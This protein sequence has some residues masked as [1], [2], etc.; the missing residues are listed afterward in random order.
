MASHSKIL[1]VSVLSTFTSSIVSGTDA[2]YSVYRHESQSIYHSQSVAVEDQSSSGYSVASLDTDSSWSMDNGEMTDSMDEILQNSDS[3]DFEVFVTT[4]DSAE[5]TELLWTDFSSTNEYEYDSIEMPSEEPGH[6]Y[7]FKDNQGEEHVRGEHYDSEPEDERGVDSDHEHNFQEH[8][9]DHGRGEDQ[10][11]VPELLKGD[12]RGDITTVSQYGHDTE[13]QDGIRAH[14]GHNGNGNYKSR[15]QSKHLNEDM[16]SKEED[17]KKG[18][19]GSLGSCDWNGKGCYGDDDCDKQEIQE[20]C[21]KFESMEDC[22]EMTRYD[23]KKCV[24]TY[25]QEVRTEETR[26]SLDTLMAA[27]RER[28]FGWTEFVVEFVCV[29]LVGL[30]VVETF[31]WWRYRGYTKLVDDPEG[32]LLITIV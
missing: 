9:S 4:M 17:T 30:A 16:D 23:E 24:W 3:P 28:F 21:T 18:P 5:S 20:F 8:P 25:A 6:D 12:I 11:G 26:F 27:R 10:S 22:T 29:M 31:R 19:K 13:T 15:F 2:M 14:H 1:L 32:D 7:D